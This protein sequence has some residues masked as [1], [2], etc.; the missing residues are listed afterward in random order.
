MGGIVATACLGREIRWRWDYRRLE[1]QVPGLQRRAYG[2]RDGS[3]LTV[4]YAVHCSEDRH[5]VIL[6]IFYPLQTRRA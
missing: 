6:L 4:R 1:T 3:V 5:V 2:Y